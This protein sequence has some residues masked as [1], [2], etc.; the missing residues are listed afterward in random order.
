MESPALLEQE[1]CLTSQ[2]HNWQF[3]GFLVQKPGSNLLRALKVLWKAGREGK[4]LYA[5]FLLCVTR[6]VF[7]LSLS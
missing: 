2:Y 4:W 3:P 5:E 1:L 6:G 7:H